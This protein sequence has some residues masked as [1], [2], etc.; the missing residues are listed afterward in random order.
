MCSLITLSDT[1][2]A[3]SF[4]LLSSGMVMV[5]HPC[6]KVDRQLQLQFCK[7]QVANIQENKMLIYVN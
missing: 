1:E 6:T 3:T 7:N 5:S 4:G 2:T